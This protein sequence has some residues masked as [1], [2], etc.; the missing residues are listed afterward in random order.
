MARA[1]DRVKRMPAEIEKGQEQDRERDQIGVFAED[2][3]GQVARQHDAGNQS[4][5]R[6]GALTGD[7]IERIGQD[8]ALRR[9]HGHSREPGHIEAAAAEKRRSARS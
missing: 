4:E 9:G 2:R 8:F 6:H 5:R 7:V 1:Q 3:L